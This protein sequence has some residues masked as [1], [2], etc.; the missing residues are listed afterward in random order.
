MK[1]GQRK[2]PSCPSGGSHTRRATTPA[3]GNSWPSRCWQN[4]SLEIPNKAVC[5]RDSLRTTRPN[6]S[7]YVQKATPHLCRMSERAGS[8]GRHVEGRRYCTTYDRW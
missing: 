4:H 7:C 1:A 2:A 3:G 8:Y 5:E 6:H